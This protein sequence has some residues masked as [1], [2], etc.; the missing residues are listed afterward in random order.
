MVPISSVYTVSRL[1][2]KQ[3]ACNL[4]LSGLESRTSDYLNKISQS[5]IKEI[6]RA[7]EHQVEPTQDKIMCLLQEQFNKDVKVLTYRNV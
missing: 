6:I 2:I 3:S 1:L 7:T 4:H 5:N